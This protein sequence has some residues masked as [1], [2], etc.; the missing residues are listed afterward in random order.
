MTDTEHTHHDH[1]EHD[2]DCDCD[3]TDE[4]HEHDEDC[5]CEDKDEH[6]HDHEGH[7]HSHEH[8]GH[9]HDDHEGH[10]HDHVVLANGEM[11]VNLHEE[12]AIIASGSLNL[13][14]VDAEVISSR[15]AE[16]LAGVAQ[17]TEDAG[18]LIG[19][20]KATLAR[21]DVRMLTTTAAETEVFVKLSPQSEVQVN[22]VLIVFMVEEAEL[23]AWG[24][25]VMDSLQR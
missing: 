2:E 4:Q 10:G 12:G 14:G 11:Q 18:G 21:T 17:K 16:G 20:L 6:D 19:H 5:D 15:L 3:E 24:Q 1:E 25:E 8:E 13:V 9:D 23:L 7:D 22:L